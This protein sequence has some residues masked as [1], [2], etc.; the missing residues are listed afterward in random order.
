MGTRDKQAIDMVIR[1]ICEICASS[2]S[3]AEA[4]IELQASRGDLEVSIKYKPHCDCVRDGDLVVAFTYDY[5]TGCAGSMFFLGKI[6]IP[7][8]KTIEKNCFTT[9]KMHFKPGTAIA[10]M[11]EDLSIHEAFFGKTLSSRGRGNI[12]VRRLDKDE[13]AAYEE[14]IALK[15]QEHLV[16]RERLIEELE[17]WM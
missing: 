10:V 11:R 5:E 12:V 7:S 14:A 1:E 17:H 9:K 16:T 3:P 4:R 8:G 13:E 6:D 2:T 15:V